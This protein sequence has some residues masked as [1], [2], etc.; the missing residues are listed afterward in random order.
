MGSGKTCMGKRHLELSRQRDV[1]GVG[2]ACLSEGIALVCA[3]S[4]RERG[5]IHGAR[6]GVSAWAARL[7]TKK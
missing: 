6:G 3:R 5:H 2:L 4:G 7:G 1:S